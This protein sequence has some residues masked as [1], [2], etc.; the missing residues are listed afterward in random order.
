MP[1]TYDPVEW[2][3]VSEIGFRMNCE[4]STT[5]YLDP[6]LNKDSEGIPQPSLGFDGFCR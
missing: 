4:T 6:T 3:Q 5:A 2:C 1:L